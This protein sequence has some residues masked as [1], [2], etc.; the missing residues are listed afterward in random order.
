MLEVNAPH[1]GGSGC[2]FPA[3]P[4]P[5][6]EVWGVRVPYRRQRY[7]KLWEVEPHIHFCNGRPYVTAH[8]VE[9]AARTGSSA[10]EGAGAVSCT[11]HVVPSR[12]TGGTWM[13]HVCH[14]DV[15]Q[16]RTGTQT[17][18]I[19]VQIFSPLS[20]SFID[21]GLIGLQQHVTRRIASGDPEVS[22]HFTRWRHGTGSASGRAVDDG[23]QRYLAC[24][25][26]EIS[27][28]FTELYLNLQIIV[29]LQT[30]QK[31]NQF[32]RLSRD[33]RVVGNPA[34][35]SYANL[36]QKSIIL[37]SI[38]VI[39]IH[40]N[41]LVLDLYTTTSIATEVKTWTWNTLWLGQLMLLKGKHRVTKRRAAVYPGNQCKCKKNTSYLHSGVCRVPRRSASL[42][43]QRRPAVKQITAV[44]SPLCFTASRRSQS[45]QKSTAPGDRHQNARMHYLHMEAPIRVI[46]RDLK[47]RNVVITM[48][49]VLKVLWEM[50]TREV[51]FK[52]LEGL[53]V[54]W[55]VVEKNEIMI[56][57]Y[58][59]F[60]CFQRLT[61]PSSCPRSFAE[62]MRL[63]WDAEAKKRPSFKQIIS[64]LESMS[65]D[66]KLPDQCNSF[67]HNKAEWRCEIEETLERL[68]KLERDLS[69]K[70]QELKER[71]QRL[72]L[73][74]KK[75]TEQSHTPVGDIYIYIYI[76][77][78]TVSPTMV[79]INLRN[80]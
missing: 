28:N 79:Y 48:D 58:F 38:N 12:H 35:V 55:L 68:K 3:H 43:C 69:F 42:H 65:N 41:M 7:S 75:L 66:S 6:C 46:H 15:P 59:C 60:S 13:P 62:L 14:T 76:Y 36:K 72:K 27:S 26:T 30:G 51:P 80:L 61:I 74:E 10:G 47:S 2:I 53:Q 50:L 34:G 73:W 45:V 11:V 1:N 56:Q 49:G 67:L 29:L 18:I 64:N 17:R 32:Y 78:F 9:G 25:A 22:T 16:K 23:W 33:F 37:R 4:L 8:T 39:E 44:T 52:G 20:S 5:H 24:S 54:A 40:L 71:E 21:T 57:K 77:I 70:E 19:P 63:C 31:S